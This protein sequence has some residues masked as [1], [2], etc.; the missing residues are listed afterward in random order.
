MKIRLQDNRFDTKAAELG[1]DNA[2]GAWSC[3]GGGVVPDGESFDEVRNLLRAYSGKSLA[4]LRAMGVVSL[5]GDSDSDSDKPFFKLAESGLTLKI[6]TGNLMGVVAFRD[7]V[8]GVCVQLEIA[9]RFDTGQRQ[10]F[11][12]Y[13]LSSLATGIDFAGDVASTNATTW[14]L[15]LAVM[16]VQRLAAVGSVGLYKQY[17]THERNDL[18]FRGRLDM[19]RHLRRNYPV[20]ARIAYSFREISFDVPV[21]H[22]IRHAA[23][24]IERKWPD[25]LDNYVE[26]TAFLRDLSSCTPTWSPQS[27]T[28]CLRSRDCRQPVGHPYFAGYYEPLRRIARLILEDGAMGIFGGSEDEACG[29]VFNGADVWEEYLGRVLGNVP[30]ASVLGQGILRHPNNRR[31]S[32]PIYLYRNGDSWKKRAYPDFLWRRP[33]AEDVQQARES[34]QEWDCVLDAKYKH[35]V[36]ESNDN[37]TFSAAREDRFQ[38]MSYLHVTKARHGVFLSPMKNEERDELVASIVQEGADGGEDSLQWKPGYFVE[39]ELAGFGGTILCIPFSVPP[40]FTVEEDLDGRRY[41]ESM[42][43]AEADLIGRIS[44]RVTAP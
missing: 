28:S 44:T 1:F 27:C 41:A 34:A 16:F 14:D 40:G 24:K 9:S 32:D 23:A 22:L 5:Y 18:N 25:V 12:N 3:S 36:R 43:A 13:I 2:S 42:R 4:E 39:G 11:L 30:A 7:I 15:L 33:A 35:Q 26:A 8:S 29:V 6:E 37:G 17:R 31:K 10:C 38:M 19:D 21:N 20:A